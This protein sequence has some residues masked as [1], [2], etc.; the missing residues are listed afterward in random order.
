MNWR[1]IL[2]SGPSKSDHQRLK[3][4]KRRIANFTKGD[5]NELTGRD[6]GSMGRRDV[7]FLSVIIF[8]LVSPRNMISLTSAL[9]LI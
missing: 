6:D 8:A 2:Q 9:A 7:I 5:H 1:E 4:R 3:K